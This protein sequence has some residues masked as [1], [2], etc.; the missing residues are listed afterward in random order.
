MSFGLWKVCYRIVCRRG[1]ATAAHSCR[2][3]CMFLRWQSQSLW[4]IE[5]AATG[6]FCRQ[7]FERSGR[8]GGAQGRAAVCNGGSSA[9]IK[10]M[11]ANDLHQASGL[12]RWL[13]GYGGAQQ[14][15]RNQT[16][17]S[18]QGK[19]RNGGAGRAARNDEAA[20]RGGISGARSG[21]VNYWIVQ[22]VE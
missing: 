6:L 20:V 4:R 7:R 16:A 18:M 1:I 9:R 15:K 21:N 5:C 14:V 22:T 12:W 2:R 10:S 19:P 17:P 8:S 13:A 3:G 11:D